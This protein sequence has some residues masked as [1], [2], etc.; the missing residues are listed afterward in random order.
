MKSSKPQG[1]GCFQG[2][3][4][5]TSSSMKWVIPLSANITKWSNTLKLFV[6]KKSANFSRVFDHFLLLALKGLIVFIV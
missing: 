5:E 4:K 2:L 1:F 3:A 6:G